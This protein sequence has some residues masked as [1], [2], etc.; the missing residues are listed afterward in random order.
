VLQSTIETGAEICLV[1]NPASRMRKL[2]YTRS[3]TG[4]APQGILK[5][6]ANA[7][8]SN[9]NGNPHHSAQSVIRWNLRSVCANI[10]AQARMNKTA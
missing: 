1:V 3:P 6:F 8:I 2:I 7:L 4:G 9:A 10:G 5:C